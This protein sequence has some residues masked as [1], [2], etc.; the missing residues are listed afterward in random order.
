MTF[1]N[2]WF[3]LHWILGI[4]AGLVLMVV[5]TTGGILSFEREILRAINTDLMEVQPAKNAVAL[6]PEELLKRIQA[7]YPE[8]TIN[9]LTL[10]NNP[11]EAARVN[12][13]LEGTGKRARK[14]ETRYVDPYTGNVRWQDVKGKSFFRT[15]LHLHRRLLLDQP[16]KQI[17]GASTIALII[18]VLSGLYLRWPKTW[19]SLK[20]WFTFNVQKTG[21]SFVSSLHAVIGTWMMIFLLLVSFT[22]LYW[23]YD[24]YRAG[25]YAISG[26]PQPV[27][28][29]GPRAPQKQSND[30]SDTVS[31]ETDSSFNLAGHAWQAFEQ[32]VN[33]FGYSTATLRLPKNGGDYAF[34]YFD[35]DPQHPRARNRMTVSAETG[36]AIEH[37]RYED[38]AL[39]EKLMSSMLPL[40]TGEYFGIIG[41]ILLFIASLS[42]LLFGITG[43]MLYLDRRKTAKLRREAKQ[44]ANLKTVPLAQADTVIVYASQ[45]GSAER[46]AWL[47]GQILQDTDRAIALTGL[48]ELTP[49]QLADKSLVLLIAST[50]GEGE[51]PDSARR[52][53]KH[54]KAVTAFNPD[55]RFAVLALGDSHYEHFCTFG[56]ALDNWMRQSGATALQ[57]CTTVDKLNP[58]NLQAWQNLLIQLGGNREV[59]LIAEPDEWRLTER[60]LLNPGSQGMPT[61]H[62]CFEPINAKTVDWQAGD[63]VEL[64]LKDNQTTATR[65]YS[66]ASIPETGGLQLLVRQVRF[67][68]NTLG[69]GSGFLTDS[70]TL[71][72][73][74]YL[75]IQ[76]HSAFHLDTNHSGPLIL[77]GNGT[78]LAGLRAHLQQRIQHGHYRNWLLFGERN[79]ASDFYYQDE[80]NDWLKNG[81]LEKLTTA[82]SREQAGYVQDKLREAG[83]EIRSWV[84]Q[85]AVILVCGSADT[86]AKAVDDALQNILSPT[87]YQTLLEHNRYLRD[88]Y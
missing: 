9:A 81:Q 21:R 88:I 64:T 29:G 8:R 70:L 35:P 47:T 22:G 20:T 48:G 5:G 53:A 37:S 27:R 13:A 46:L 77:I 4:T 45:N 76:S 43:F 32:H 44:Q 75:T 61:Y 69:K 34:T 15:V 55:L 49:E 6:A 24:W 65:Q 87:D 83:E 2:I 36:E 30:L 39:N 17:V 28:K 16:G 11:F 33:E 1:K 50:F 10:S 79:Q 82:F 72:Q 78:G 66:I 18:L 7:K 73:I 62:L 86:M 67:E 51:A 42:L 3:Q 56:L 59:S 54:L 74:A 52:F 31:R 71:G 84:Q 14:G 40:H 19:H 58:K 63:L 12:F 38:K 60:T 23:S 68:N 80:L 26:V 57:P 85:G 41:R 25:L